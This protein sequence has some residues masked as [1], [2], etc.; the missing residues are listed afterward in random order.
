MNLTTLVRAKQVISAGAGSVPQD[1]LISMLIASASDAACQFTGRTF[2]RLT[3]SNMIL[4]G[5]GTDRIMLPTNPV[6]Q[7]SGVVAV[8]GYQYQPTPNN[9]VGGPNTKAVGY[10]WDRK[11]LYLTGGPLF[12]RGRRNVSIGSITTAYTTTEAAA[13]PAANGNAPT[14]T[15]SPVTGAAVD[16]QGT[17]MTTGGFAVTDQGVTYAAN[18]AVLSKVASNVQVGQYA[19]DGAGTYTFAAGDAGRQVTMAYD[20]IPSSVEQ[21]VIETVGLKLTQRMNYGIRSHSI[22]GESSQSE[23]SDDALSPSAKTLLQPYRFVISP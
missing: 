19:F 15:Y 13:V 1:P 8:D 9:A 12:C 7:V 2:Q 14:V 18:G 23:P 5:T 22:A 17:P 16:S 4:S 20:F 11:F 21:A 6:V 3:L 10:M